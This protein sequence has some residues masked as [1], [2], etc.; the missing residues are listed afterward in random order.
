[1]D[2]SFNSLWLQTALCLAGWL[3]GVVMHL[4]WHPQRRD[5]SDAWDVLTRL[6]WLMVLMAGLIILGEWTRPDLLRVRWPVGLLAHWREVVWPLTLHSAET[7][8]RS[9]HGLLP[10][11]PL[12][13]VVPPVLTLL[14]WRIIRLPYRYAARRPSPVEKM[15]LSMS[16]VLAWGWIAVEIVHAWR[17]LPEW[18]ESLRLILR[19]ISS[20]IVMALSQV[21]LIR[22]VI[23]WEE[24]QAVNDEKDP[25]RAVE[26]TFARWRSVFGLA[27]LDLLWLLWTQYR[28]EG[29]SPA[30]RWMLLEALLVFASLPVVVALTPGSLVAQGALALR[31]LPR[32]LLP[33]LSI[34]LTAVAV[35]MLVNYAS[36]ILHD[37][38][39]PGSVW[40]KVLLPVRALVLAMV[41]SWLFLAT[42]FTFLRH[43]LKPIASTGGAV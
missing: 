27:G 9:L 24:P 31:V 43:G 22:M 36:A 4:L 39:E 33:W 2:P 8:A 5:L 10:A 13:L 3:L 14:A 40:A 28:G 37:L 21:T 7:Y 1:M 42:V 32:V 19:L 15:L 12:A 38:A 20:A 34:A 41:H 17:M 11:W 23:D 26:E 30:G 25:L 29:G 16:A 18:L 6:P 35:L